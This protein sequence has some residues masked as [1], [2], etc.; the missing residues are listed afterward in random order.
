MHKAI[1]FLTRRSDL[2]IDEFRSW[3]LGRHRVLAEALPGLRRHTFN[4]LPSGAPCDAV[5]EQWFD[6]A[7]ALEDA[8]R[9]PQG[10]LVAED[11]AAHVGSRTRCVVQE[12][13][14]TL[15]RGDDH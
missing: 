6:S 10:R 4:L 3:W 8:Y 2:S 1:I 5:V 12:F 13:A 7:Q 11:S 14:F 15:P 9:T